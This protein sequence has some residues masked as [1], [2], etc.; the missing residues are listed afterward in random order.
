ML[1][2]QLKLFGT[3]NVKSNDSLVEFKDSCNIIKF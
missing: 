3:I 2:L 1:Q